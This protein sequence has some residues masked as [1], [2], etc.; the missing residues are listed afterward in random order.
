MG[1][2]TSSVAPCD[3]VAPTADL[4]SLLPPSSNQPLSQSSSVTTSTYDGVMI[5]DSE[6]AALYLACG[7]R[8]NLQG[9]TTTEVNE[10]FLK[11]LTEPHK[12]SFCDLLKRQKHTAVGPASVFICHA[13]S[14]MF[15]DLI[16]AL[17]YHFR[18][19]SGV[20]VWIDIISS[21][22]H[23]IT[24]TAET[25]CSS[26][27]SVIRHISHT[28]IVFSPSRSPVSVTRRWCLY[29]LYCS[30]VSK[31]KFD[32]A[33]SRS[34]YDAFVKDA[35]T[36]V[37]G[38]LDTMSIER[39]RCSKESDG[40]YLLKKLSDEVG[41]KRVNEKITNLIR[42]WLIEELR[43]IIK[44]SKQNYLLIDC[45]AELHNAN[46]EFDEAES[47]FTTCYKKRRKELGDEHVE[48]LQSMAHLAAFYRNKAMY[49]EAQTLYV[50]CLQLMRRVMSSDHI[51]T[52][53]AMHHLAECYEKLD[54]ATQAESLYVECLE[55]RRKVLGSDHPDTIDTMRHLAT[56]L[57]V[58]GKHAEA[59]PL[60]VE[61]L[62]RTK[63]RLGEDH[64]DTLASQNNLAS[65]YFRI[66][67]YD[68]AEILYKS[69]LQ[70][71][72]RVLDSNHPDLLSSINNLAA[73]YIHQ[74]KYAKAQPLYAEYLQKVR[75][76]R[77]DDH[78]DTLK[79]LYFLAITY[80]KLGMKDHAVE[81]YTECL[82]R[83]RRVLGDDHPDTKATED[84]LT[85]INLKDKEEIGSVLVCI[86]KFFC[87][88]MI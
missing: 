70:S 85:Q 17:L 18:D 2:N 30:A 64:A 69:C 55:G 1:S 11:P 87:C 24:A 41:F 48:T 79:S 40:E 32:I 49:R 15:L 57:K 67:R 77:S 8:D 84:A 86:L 58:L 20:I 31:V 50:S 21:N 4:Y 26:L 66:G 53:T 80:D 27:R 19:S 14:S 47:L 68:E 12:I 88:G 43:Y 74:H 39:G 42:E 65:L 52:L 13:H 16:D 6:V 71:R 60:Y 35:A 45:L 73:T 72:L 59:E 78:P 44:S 62:D 7:G 5:S 23:I 34:Q 61:C 29:E 22:Q 63:R 10:K 82:E 76:L 37:H 75:K 56:V 46:E 83:M 38:I 81:V 54:K 36:S 33:M 3:E 51:D 9:L 28:V 25:T